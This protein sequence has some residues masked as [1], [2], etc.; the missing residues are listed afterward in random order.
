MATGLIHQVSTKEI[1]CGLS[2]NT[3]VKETGNQQIPFSV[4]ITYKFRDDELTLK[5]S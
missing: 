5:N 4:G 1:I 2:F 3:T